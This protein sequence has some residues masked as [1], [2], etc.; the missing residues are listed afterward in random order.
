MLSYILLSLFPGVLHEVTPIESP[1]INEVL[2]ASSTIPDVPFYSQFADISSPKWKKVG[3]GITSLTMV[4]DYYKPQIATVNELLEQGLDEGAYIAGAGWS[5]Q[6]LVRVSKNYG[7]NGQ[8]YDLSGS[9][10]KAAF[11]YFKDQLKDGPIIVSVH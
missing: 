11:T 10:S 8:T 3:C 5:H 6:G 4:V 2:L 9:T 1:S 7:L